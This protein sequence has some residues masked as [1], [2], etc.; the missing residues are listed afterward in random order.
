MVKL[1]GGGGEV[2]DKRGARGQSVSQEPRGEVR[3]SKILLDPN[4]SE[5]QRCQVCSVWEI[6]SSLTLLQFWLMWVP[7]PL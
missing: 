1:G 4:P 2:R 3:T 5:F 6:P 7:P